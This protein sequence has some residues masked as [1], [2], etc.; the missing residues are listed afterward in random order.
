HTISLH[1]ALPISSLSSQDRIH[2]TLFSA[3]RN[4][5]FESPY[6]RARL[7][8]NECLP[9]SA[10]RTPSSCRV[11][12]RFWLR[13]IVLAIARDEMRWRVS[14]SWSSRQDRKSTRLNSSHGSISYAV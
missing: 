14:P 9:P 2:T 7:E 3:R 4:S 11:T 1:A 10:T 13:W 12:L 8:E 5:G 6:C